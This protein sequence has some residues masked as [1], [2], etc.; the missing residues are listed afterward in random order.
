M[1]SNIRTEI[2]AGKPQKQAVAIA[3][4]VARRSKKADGGAAAYRIAQQYAHGGKVYVGPIRSHVPGRTDR[5][6]IHVPDGAYVLPAD[7]VSSMGEGNTEAGFKVADSV[8]GLDSPTGR[9]SGGLVKKYGLRGAY[10][11]NPVPAIVAGGEYVIDPSVV[12]GLGGGDM[13]KGHAKLD[14][15]CN[16][17]R[18]KHIKT[19]KRLPKPAKG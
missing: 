16:K 8:Y 6:N 13:D 5:L 19:L 9:A 4:D 10:H 7:V 15:F 17:Q 18:A 14:E 11:A 3:L 1:S 2:A 12:S